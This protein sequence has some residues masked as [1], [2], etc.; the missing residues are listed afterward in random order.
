[1]H[2]HPACNF[3]AD[4]RDGFEDDPADLQWLFDVFIPLARRTGC[5]HM[6]FI[7]D[8]DDSLRAELEAQT[9][10]L[11]QYFDVRPCFDLEEVRQ[12]LADK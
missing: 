8:R 7:I 4:T 2:E 5:E 3:I 12:F 1:M 6:F 11:K 10:E 9:G